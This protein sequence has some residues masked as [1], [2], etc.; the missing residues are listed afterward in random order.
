[1]SAYLPLSNA[2]TEAS[3]CLQCASPLNT[4]CGFSNCALNTLADGKWHVDFFHCEC[5]ACFH[6]T[7]DT[8]GTHTAAVRDTLLERHRFSRLDALLRVDEPLEW[9]PNAVPVLCIRG[10]MAWAPSQTPLRALLDELACVDSIFCSFGKTARFCATEAGREMFQSRVTS[11]I[12]ELE[13]SY[14]VSPPECVIENADEFLYARA[15]FLRV[16]VAY[17]AMRRLK[18]DLAFRDTS[19]A[20]DAHLFTLALQLFADTHLDLQVFCDAFG[21]WSDAMLER[22]TYRNLIPTEWGA[23]LFA[24]EAAEA[25][26]IVRQMQ[27]SDCVLLPPLERYYP[28]PLRAVYSGE[29]LDLG[30]TLVLS[31][32]WSQVDDESRTKAASFAK[33]FLRK[34]AAHKCQ[35]RS[36]CKM[37]RACLS[38]QPVLLAFLLNLLEVTSFG[39]Y[40]TARIQPMWRARLGIR[41]SFHWDRFDLDTWCSA[42][43]P[44]TRTPCPHCEAA[45]GKGRG[46]SHSKHVCDTCSYIERNHRFLFFSVKE[47]YAYA[48]KLHGLLDSMLEVDSNWQTHCQLLR[49][50]TDDTRLLLSRAYDYNEPLSVERFQKMQMHIDRQLALQH[51]ANKPT[52]SRLDKW[53]SFA[54]HLLSTFETIHSASVMSTNWTGYQRPQDLLMAPSASSQRSGELP[55]REKW[56]EFFVCEA[57]LEHLDGNRWCDVYT[58]AQVE[59][60]ARYCELVHHDLQPPLLAVVGVS[61]ATVE[62]LVSMHYASAWRNMPDNRIG[63]ICRELFEKRR[64]DFHIVH[65]FLDC[66]SKSATV[67]ELRLDA[68]T[69]VLQASS[70]RVRNRIEPWN[71]LPRGV[72]CI[73]FCRTHKHVFADISPP[74]D[75][76]RE[77]EEMRA[78]GGSAIPLETTATIHGVCGAYYDHKLGG[79]VCSRTIQS[80][81]QSYLEKLGLKCAVWIDDDPK[82]A[83]QAIE[84]REAERSCVGK[85]LESRSLLGNSVKIG[86]AVY[87]LCVKCGV[88]CEWNDEHMTT[89]GMTCGREVRIAERERYT[90]LSQ[91]VTRH[92][93]AVV[94]DDSIP[95]FEDFLMPE[96]QLNERGDMFESVPTPVIDKVLEEEVI[97]NINIGVRHGYT[98]GKNKRI[99]KASELLMLE[100]GKTTSRADEARKRNQPGV[101]KHR[102]TSKRMPVSML[103]RQIPTG[104]KYEQHEWNMLSDEE[105]IYRWTPEGRT[106]WRNYQAL[107]THSDVAMGEVLTHQL[108]LKKSMDMDAL[109]KEGFFEQQIMQAAAADSCVASTLRYMRRVHVSRMSDDQIVRLRDMMIE[110][111]FFERRVEIVC[112]YCHARCARSSHFHRL[113]VNNQYN[114]LVDGHLG[115]PLGEYG[116]VYI[117]LCA[118]CFDS[119]SSLLKNKPVPYVHELFVHRNLQ[120]ER[121]VEKAIR[122]ASK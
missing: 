36:F 47:F 37:M 33:V 93:Q 5:K 61:P 65:Y 2:L 63:V 76:E 116:L 79:V 10:T 54:E 30:S 107:Q 99:A 105:M 55:P 112:A 71:P 23:S 12:E 95:L 13:M 21:D 72:D 48:I 69:T 46:A 29:L 59:N 22:P 92:A 26:N 109:R 35:V 14:Q 49:N 31:N 4:Q 17:D 75:F 62:M 42:C 27:M 88:V 38:E 32:I 85:L 89:Y 16:T 119:C 15:L 83:R 11:R 120:R 41:R 81:S 115:K 53:F 57:P 110:M 111:G 90:D 121:K 40:E 100:N 118:K 108:L 3:I 19:C 94:S 74:I 103:H 51:D 117:W 68:Q 52:M 78:R 66:M 9:T 58:L 102:T 8:G 113:T 67:K 20:R 73:Y 87:T 39:N 1:M 122:F 106:F 7:C 45:H 60:V 28:H 114:T 98:N 25:R 70:L 50:A 34:C 18:T 101:F 64:V 84:A 91:F 96:P 6:D 44:K 86:R 56:P 80:A 82:R 104:E 77:E 97:S 24:S 43:H